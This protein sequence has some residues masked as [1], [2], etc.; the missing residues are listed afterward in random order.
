MPK[1]IHRQSAIS[2]GFTIDDHAAGRPLAYKGPRFAPTETVRC[3]TAAEEKLLALLHE[4]KVFAALPEA[5]RGRI[6]Q[7]L[8]NLGNL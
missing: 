2:R 3:Y 4:V 5:L 6:N 1:L 8:D 7:D